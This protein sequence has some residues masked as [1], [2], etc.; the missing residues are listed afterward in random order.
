M[1]DSPLSSSSRIVCASGLMCVLMFIVT[2]IDGHEGQW[3]APLCGRRASSPLSACQKTEARPQLCVCVCVC[4]SPT[5]CVYVCA[6]TSSYFCPGGVWALVC[7]C[8]WHGDSRVR[9]QQ[10]SM[11]QVPSVTPAGHG[12]QRDTPGTALM[13]GGNKVCVCV[14]M[15]VCVCVSFVSRQ[16]YHTCTASHCEFMNV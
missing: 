15:V 11:S 3:V 6:L 5:L 16:I 13:D 10:L 8:V 9:C 4:V 12:E 14:S 2:E 7:L 1:L